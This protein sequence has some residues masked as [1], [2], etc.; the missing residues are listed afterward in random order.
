MSRVYTKILIITS[1]K[2]RLTTFK[3]TKFNIPTGTKQC[4]KNIISPIYCP[5]GGG[6][7]CLI[8]RRYAG[9]WCH[10]DDVFKN[11]NIPLRKSC[12][13]SYTIEQDN[14]LKNDLQNDTL[15]WDNSNTW[16]K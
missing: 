16:N 10:E 4:R 13:E 1:M 8:D 7:S 11:L 2:K 14:A 3:K 15:F 5:C 12:M 6:Q 9:D